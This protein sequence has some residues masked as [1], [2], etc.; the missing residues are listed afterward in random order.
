MAAAAATDARGRTRRIHRIAALNLPERPSSQGEHWTVSHD[1]G[2]TWNTWLRFKMKA[3]FE[4]SVRAHWAE[5]Q[6][7]E[8]CLAKDGKGKTAGNGVSSRLWL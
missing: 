3:I 8:W 7:T 1:K 6:E 2:M 4:Y 5:L